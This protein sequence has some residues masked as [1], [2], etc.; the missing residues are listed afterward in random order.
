[1]GM[2]D[3][4][5]SRL[6]TIVLVPWKEMLKMSISSETHNRLAYDMWC[7]N[8]LLCKYTQVSSKTIKGDY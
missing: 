7:M 5:V 2:T 4:P 3:V 1:M 6:S 8:C